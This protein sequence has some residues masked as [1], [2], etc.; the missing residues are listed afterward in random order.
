MIGLPSDDFLLQVEEAMSIFQDM[1]TRGC[2]RN[3]IT[4]SSL[5][6][7]CEKSGRCAIFLDL[8][9]FREIFTANLEQD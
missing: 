1:V 6:T 8:S 5:I 9:G 4:Y 7:A 2:E 3:V